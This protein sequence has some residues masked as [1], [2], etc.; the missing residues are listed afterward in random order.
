MDE[1]LIVKIEIV[2]T[3]L[4]EF[5]KPKI[6]LGTG[7]PVRDGLI[8]TARHVLYCE[9]MNAASERVLSWQRS[10]ESQP[11]YVTKVQQSAIVFE[12]VEFDVALVA[13]DTKPLGK[14]P[15]VLDTSFP[16]SG[17]DQARWKSFGYPRA[18]K[19][20]GIR[21]K[22]PAEGTFFPPDRDYY[23]QQLT[24]EG[25]A[26]ESALWKGMSGAPVFRSDT[27]KLV[28]VL[29]RTPTKYQDTAQNLEDVFK[30]RLIAV[31]IPYLL[32]AGKCED[33]RQLALQTEVATQ[34][35]PE[36]KL[37]DEFRQYLL[38]KLTDELMGLRST[39]LLHEQLA[40]ELDVDLEGVVLTSKA[41]AT[42]LATTL[43]DTAVED[44]LSC[45]AAATAD[46]V[47][48]GGMRFSSQTKPDTLAAI[49]R[50]AQALVGWLVIA[51]MD[52][53]YLREVLPEC[54]RHTSLFF[55][56]KSVQ[57]KT[58]IEIVLAR[59]FQRKADFVHETGS[60][61][62]SRYLIRVPPSFFKW[63]GET[64]VSKAFVEIWNQ[65]F[66]EIKEQKLK[67][68]KLNHHEIKRLNAELRAKRKHRR[69]P[70]HYYIAFTGSDYLAP[71]CV[72]FVEGIYRDLLSQLGEMTVIEYGTESE[73]DSRWLLV[74]EA[75]IQAAINSFYNEINGLN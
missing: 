71:E 74:P 5:G 28:G 70:E 49:K 63:D 56:L 8:L 42:D 51:S 58:G 67:D 10:D 68:Y 26:T 25:N 48:E 64:S 23:V 9:K 61:Q 29:I 13:C 62:P 41:V 54:S 47:V 11:Y 3:L 2:S 45:I 72:G 31:S 57:S 39:S 40:T 38:D 34:L 44:A 52:E 33:F 75:D 59:R 53:N 73:Q 60:D 12:S 6:S 24:S 21:I 4:D 22:T 35:L 18:G 46:C 27:N 43:V 15:A 55:R 7:Y 69:S 65:V 17:V 30:E 20:S 50:T 37:H 19:E 14:I 16:V 66:P 32:R 1:N 36:P